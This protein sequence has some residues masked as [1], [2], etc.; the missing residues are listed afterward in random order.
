MGLTQAALVRVGAVVALGVAAGCGSGVVVNAVSQQRQAI[1]F[2]QEVNAASSLARILLLAFEY[3]ELTGRYPESVAQ[4]VAAMP[5]KAKLGC[6]W[7]AKGASPGYRL[8]IRRSPSPDMFLATATPVNSLLLPPRMPFLVGED[9]MVR[10]LTGDM[11]SVVSPAARA[12]CPAVNDVYF[13]PSSHHNR[14]GYNLYTEGNYA[15]ALREFN[16]ALSYDPFAPNSYINRANALEL[17]NKRSLAYESMQ[18]GYALDLKNALGQYGMGRHHFFAGRYREA[19]QCYT[20]ALALEPDNAFHNHGAGRAYQMLG[21]RASAVRHF[22]R[23]LEL[24]PRGKAVPLVKAW[25]TSVGAPIPQLP[26]GVD[27]LL[28]QRRFEELDAQ[29]AALLRGRKKDRNGYTLYQQATEVLVKMPQ[30]ESL[31]ADWLGS[32]TNS[33]Y[34]CLCAGS[35]YIDHAWLARGE[36][37]S[38]VV[39]TDGHRLFRERMETAAAH[40]RRAWT[41]DSTDSLAPA[42]LIHTAVGLG[43]PPVE[44]E[45]WFRRAVSADNTDIDSYKAKLNYLKPCWHGTDKQML[46]FGRECFRRAPTNS[47]VAGILGEAHW[48]VDGDDD[49]LKRPEVWAEIKAAYEGVLASFPESDEARNWLA[50]SA[51]VAGDYRT[52]AREFDAIQ[53]RWVPK[54]W[55]SKPYF[56]RV[57]SEV[58]ARLGQEVESKL[59]SQTR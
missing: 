46:D 44:M 22:T 40:L 17:M 6:D 24:D 35:F 47:A 3:R 2:R 55:G 32:E 25:L 39:T 23:Y 15:Q 10:V 12:S 28:E 38:R 7:I 34:A 26:E 33:H 4:L 54:C 9:R 13:E 37:P 30:S 27:L 48:A 16:I 56:L 58:Q 50:R 18:V 59:G 49:H 29:L 8:Q 21:D 1:A 31:I 20:N 19:A 5:D 51:Y 43:W 11:A 14:R 41:L 52:A 42:Y 36:G 57:K 53:E 45:R